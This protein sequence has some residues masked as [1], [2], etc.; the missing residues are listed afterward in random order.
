MFVFGLL[1]E[2]VIGMEAK[3]AEISK[4]IRDHKEVLLTEEAAKNALVM[5]FLQALG[6]NV[7]RVSPLHT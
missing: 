5:P 4:V 3:L 1:G 2:A 7:W 6:F